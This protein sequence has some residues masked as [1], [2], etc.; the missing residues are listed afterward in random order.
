MKKARS[1]LLSTALNLL[2]A[3]LAFAEAQSPLWSLHPPDKIRAVEAVSPGTV[4]VTELR[5]RL[6]KNKTQARTSKTK[7]HSHE[8][9]T[10]RSLSGQGSE[11]SKDIGEFKSSPLSLPSGPAPAEAVERF[12]QPRA[13]GDR[14]RSWAEDA[15]ESYYCDVLVFCFGESTSY[16]PDTQVSVGES[17]VIEAVNSGFTTFTKSGSIDETDYLEFEDFFSNVTPSG[18]IDFF[19][20]QVLWQPWEF[21]YVM[22]I[23]GKDDDNQKS[24]V[25]IAVSQSSDADGTWWVYRFDIGD[26]DAWCDYAMLGADNNGVYFTCNMFFWAGGNKASQI[27]SISNAMYEGGSAN[28]RIFTDVRW[29]AP[30]NA[31]IAF[32][33]QPAL[34]HWDSGTTYFVNS[35][36][37]G[38]SQ[39]V[40]WKM[41]GPRDS[42][43]SLS[44]TI[45]N[46]GS[47][48]SIGNNVDQPGTST[49]IDG[50]DSRVLSAV[51]SRGRVWATLTDDVGDNGTTSGF[52]VVKIN[53]GSGSAAPSVIRDRTFFTPGYHY[54]PAITIGGDSAEAN[55]A[56]FGSYSSSTVNASAVWVVLSPDLTITHRNSLFKSGEAPYVNVFDSRNR[57]GDYS[58]A[59]YDWFRQT[60]WGA[61]EW[62][63]DTGDAGDDD[64]NWGTAIVEVD[65]R[66]TG[67]ST[68]TTSTSTSTTSTSTTTTTTTSIGCID[69]EY[70]NQG[71][72]N[73]DDICFGP[74]IGLNSVQTH[75]HCDED[76]VYFEP[77][78]GRTYRIETF[79][80]QNGS[81]TVLEL[82]ELCGDNAVASND[83]GG[84]GRGSRIDWTPQSSA[85]LDIKIRQYN[86]SYSPG[87]SYDIR[88]SC[89]DNCV[90]P[91]FADGFELPAVVQ[92]R[93]PR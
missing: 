41:T 86:N 19:D 87:E 82:Y 34:P 13:L 65:I 53:V 6:R 67:T 68:T 51:Y 20:P 62:A 36:S 1:I 88:V 54:Y 69:D 89:I 29:P 4:N 14:I 30:N 37:G 71:D 59:A 2:L 25:F 35:W 56:L 63:N 90:P 43:P 80:M 16:P 12:D 18:S 78:I 7:V 50:G 11:Q 46:V 39:M 44:G 47:Y 76:W 8:Y 57:F 45:L 28:A 83:D 81:D 26:T 79:N 61:A 10:D 31:S 15:I 27:W 24:Y 40:L 9:R 22:L 84:V 21:Q 92:K 70:E 52:R 38:G 60:A 64:S 32:T 72:G 66:G 49:D 42:A 55:V 74:P 75:A 33:I 91:I 23:L 17:H 3:P 77:Q 48:G 58:G 93:R 73:T 5:A 85:I